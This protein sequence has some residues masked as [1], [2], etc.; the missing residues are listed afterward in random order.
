MAQIVG[1]FGLYK[2]P[3]HR[4]SGKNT[5]LNYNS[6]SSDF[7]DFTPQ[8]KVFPNCINKQ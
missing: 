6:F 3:F 8:I 1:N 2:V 4:S 5:T 7:I